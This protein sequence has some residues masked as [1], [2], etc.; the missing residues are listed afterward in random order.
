MI[1][2]GS[3][4]NQNQQ[5]YTIEDFSPL[6]IRVFVPSSDAIKLQTGM[7]AEVTTNILEG[8]VFNG[9]IK[10]INPRIDSQTGTIKVTV[11]VYDDSLQLKPGM[12]V[13]VKIIIGMKE[14]ILVIPRKALLFK[15]NKTFVFVLDQ[16]HVS[17]REVILGL[18][19]E[20]E[21][22]ITEGLNEDEVIVTVGVE[23]LKD[24]QQVRVV[25]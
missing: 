8:K 15:Q 3:R 12:F 17:Q 5:V 16:D 22:E 21:V 9:S 4:V 10:L 6:L 20:D 23:A 7:I 14:N 2:V 1:E 13:E 24:G 19:E 11:E 18:T 25:K